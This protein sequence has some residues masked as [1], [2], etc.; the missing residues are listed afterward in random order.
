MFLAAARRAS[1]ALY[2]C[3]CLIGPAAAAELSVNLTYLGQ[4]EQPFIP[5]SLAEPTLTDE[6]IKGARQ[7]LGRQPDDGPLPQAE[8]R[9]QGA[10]R[11]QG[12]DVE[13]AFKA[14]LAAGERL[15]IADLRADE[16]LAIAPCRGRSRG[17]RVRRRTE[18]D[19]L[20]LD[21]LPPQSVF[22]IAPSRAMKADALAQ[23][24]IW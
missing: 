20:R 12:G 1:S 9:P 10:A 16:L 3:A 17:R 4:A 13:A 23:Y 14:A 7:A 2:L 6:G 11:A 5:L 24:L 22:H 21:E 8:L 18:D 19:A 15:F